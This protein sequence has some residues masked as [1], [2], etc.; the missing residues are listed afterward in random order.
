MSSNYQFELYYFE[1]YFSAWTNQFILADNLLF[2]K[3][4]NLY[5][6]SLN[7]KASWVHGDKNAKSY[8]FPQTMTKMQTI[9]QNRNA[10]K[11]KSTDYKNIV[12]SISSIISHEIEQVAVPVSTS[13]WILIEPNWDCGR[14][15]WSVW[16]G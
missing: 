8:I 13:S 14:A 6:T 10:Q 9:N 16:S 7:N 15:S 5:K 11:L 3:M 2:S 1:Y 4:K 12:N